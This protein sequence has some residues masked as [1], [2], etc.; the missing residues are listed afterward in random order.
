MTQGKIHSGELA[1]QARAGEASTAL[2]NSVAIRDTVMEGAR[3]FLKQ[4]NMVLL[5][6]RDGDSQMWASLV[7][8]RPGFLSSDDGQLFDIDLNRALIDPGDPL[9]RNLEREGQLGCLIIE[10]STRKRFRING[11]ARLSADRHLQVQ[12]AE[13]FPACPKYITRR[14]MYLA[15]SQ[16]LD[17]PA[18]PTPGDDTFPA[19]SLERADA[20][21]VATQSPQG[22]FDVSHRGGSP[23]F[24]SV[25]GPRS[26]RWPEYPGNSMFNTLG[27]LVHDPHA[28]LVLADFPRHRIVQLTGTA[29]TLWDQPDPAQASGGT[30][31][32]V[33]FTAATWRELALPV[34]LTTELLDYSRFNP[35]VA[36][37]QGANTER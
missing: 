36:A 2:R 37:A 5:A 21:F 23:G 26:L 30:G 20:I 8:G 28:G 29:Q 3:G 27:N 17:T 15:A 22:G 6:S 10:L 24:V 32:F 12:I 4:Q 31:R 1:V 34:A 13:A 14:E 16:P 11:T 18:A 25:S 7:F 33:E 9:W 35:P 19:I